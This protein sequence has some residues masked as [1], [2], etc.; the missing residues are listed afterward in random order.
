[1]ASIS[2]Y[3]TCVT[4]T[5]VVLL[6]SPRIIKP[7]VRRSW[8]LMSGIIESPVKLLRLRISESIFRSCLV[9]SIK[10]VPG[11]RLL[12]WTIPGTWR[13]LMTPRYRRIITIESV[14]LTSTSSVATNP[15]TH[16]T[17]TSIS[18]VWICSWMIGTNRSIIRRIW[19]NGRACSIVPVW[20]VLYRK[21][22]KVS[23]TLQAPLTTLHI[24]DISWIMGSG[25]GQDNNS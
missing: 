21:K 12:R 10:L 16:T 4:L 15:L 18:R 6:L 17:P 1:M 3:L 14:S 25:F 20:E 22:L 5:P 11:Y 19:I 8:M 23:P 7:V 24:L 9:N 2:R 13:R